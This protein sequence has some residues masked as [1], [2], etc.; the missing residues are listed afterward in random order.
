MQIHRTQ[1]L[2]FF[3]PEPVARVGSTMRAA[4]AMGSAT[5]N[6]V[7]KGACQ[8]AG[9]RCKNSNG[10]NAALGSD[11]SD[12]GITFGIGDDRPLNPWPTTEIPW[13]PPST[14]TTQVVVTSGVTNVVIFGG[15]YTP[16]HICGPDITTQFLNDL[17]DAIN[18]ADLSAEFASHLIPISKIAQRRNDW[19]AIKKYVADNGI[20]DYKP[21]AKRPQTESCPTFCSHS[22]TL[23]GHCVKDDVPANFAFG[24]LANYILGTIVGWVAAEFAHYTKGRA[25]DVRDIPAS[26]SGARASE[27]YKG[28]RDSKSDNPRSANDKPLRDAVCAALDELVANTP[29]ATWACDPCPFTVGG[30]PPGTFG[31]PSPL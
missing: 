20:L 10:G 27:R 26:N 12:G 25:L 17:K 7:T 24:F 1:G 6:R 15:Q 19:R 30:L 16:I 21:E 8:C 11:P 23:C 3:R 5:A 18:D 2:V 13:R 28:T 29:D 31:P 14:T 22:V 4:P 9:C